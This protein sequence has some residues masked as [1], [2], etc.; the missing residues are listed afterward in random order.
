MTIQ[1][2]CQRIGKS[3]ST[4]RRWLKTGKLTAKLIDGV[5]DIP[6][7]AI[8]RLVNGY[9]NDKA[10]EQQSEGNEQVIIKRLEAEN[11]YLK[12]RIQELED[13]RERAD[14]ISLQL[15]RQLEQSQRMLEAHKEPFWRRW[16]GKDKTN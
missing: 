5:Y 14:T 11:E 7:D 8:N 2:T 12:E 10:S 6:E 13:A 1:E 15:T 16:F 4:I 9:P 3:E